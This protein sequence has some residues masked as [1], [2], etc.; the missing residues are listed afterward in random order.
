MPRPQ[1]RIANSPITLAEQVLAKLDSEPGPCVV[2]LHINSVE[3][4]EPK[5]YRAWD[6]GGEELAITKRA[7]S[8]QN[9]VEVGTY[10]RS[11]HADDL[12]GDILYAMGAL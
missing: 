9:M 12:A 8:S 7:R 11:I 1:A 5:V 6:K 4:I 2:F 10:T 3:R